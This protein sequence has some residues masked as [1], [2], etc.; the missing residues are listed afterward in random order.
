[1]PAPV[2]AGTSWLPLSFGVNGGVLVLRGIETISYPGLGVDVAGMLRIGLDL[3]AKLIDEH[4]QIF[5]FP[6]VIGTPY[7]LQHS[8]MR[9]RLSLIGHQVVQ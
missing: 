2:S 9:K 3:F 8:T 1:M 7:G 6:A 4:A 5:S